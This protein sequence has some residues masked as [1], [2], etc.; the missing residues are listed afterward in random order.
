[1]HADQK[2]SF[3]IGAILSGTAASVVFSLF[4][5]PEERQLIVGKTL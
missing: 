4:I 5:T 2:L 1:M 3:V